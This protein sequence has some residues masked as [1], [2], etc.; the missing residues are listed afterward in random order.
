MKVMGM[1][2]GNPNSRSSIRQVTT[3]APRLIQGYRPTTQLVHGKKR[4]QSK[5]I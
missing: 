3:I 2:A 1:V 5:A 4:T